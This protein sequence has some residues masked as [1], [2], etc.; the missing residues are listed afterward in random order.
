M[1]GVSSES[2]YYLLFQSP[3]WIHNIHD[4]RSQGVYDYDDP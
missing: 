2:L 4:L 3:G 1:G